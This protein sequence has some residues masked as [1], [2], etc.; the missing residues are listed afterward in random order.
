MALARPFPP[1]PVVVTAVAAAGIGTE[2]APP[3]PPAAASPG[4]FLEANSADNALEA[5]ANSKETLREVTKH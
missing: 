5:C 4:G 3:P 2:V 1:P